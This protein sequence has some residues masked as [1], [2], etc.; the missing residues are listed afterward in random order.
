[1]GRAVHPGQTSQR[2]PACWFRVTPLPP[3]ALTRRSLLPRLNRVLAGPISWRIS[4]GPLSRQPTATEPPYTGLPTA[5]DA[6][7]LNAMEFALALET[8]ERPL[9]RPSSR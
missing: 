2:L 5:H 6:S 9:R 7:Q 1:M 8:R 3:S 4:R